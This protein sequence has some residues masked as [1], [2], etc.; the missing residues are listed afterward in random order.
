[1][2][3]FMK[4]L[5]F[6]A[7]VLA[8]AG[9]ACAADYQVRGPASAPPPA[10]PPPVWDWSGIYIGANGGFGWGNTS[11]NFPPPA[12]DFANPFETFGTRPKGALAGGQIGI[13]KQMGPWAF[14]FPWV[15]GFEFTG[16]WAD[17]RQTL[18]GPLPGFPRDAWTTKLTDVETLTFRFGVPLNNWLFYAKAGGAS[19]TVDLRGVSGFPPFPTFSRT[20]RV[21]GETIGAGIEYAFTQNFIV[22]VE[23]DFIRLFPGQFNVVASNGG[24][25]AVGGNSSFD[26]QAVIGRL[27]YKFWTPMF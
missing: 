24:S 20:D 3:P 16:D 1:M 27:S 18:V 8:I 7:A 6:A 13:N 19:G 17:L 4:K 9:P 11:W 12:S 10:P 25:V 26:V 15:W 14:G 23:F 22:G 5:A 21:F 2:R